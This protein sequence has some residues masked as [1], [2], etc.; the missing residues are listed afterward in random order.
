M[1]SMTLCRWGGNIILVA[2]L[3]L[4]AGCATTPGSRTAT[5]SNVGYWLAE[6][7][8]NA[9]QKEFH[10][11]KLA[12]AEFLRRVKSDMP[13]TLHDLRAYRNQLLVPVEIRA[14]FSA[15]SPGLR[16]LSQA[17]IA[18]IEDFALTHK[19]QGAIIGSQCCKEWAGELARITPQMAALEEKVDQ[20]VRDAETLL[21]QGHLVEADKAWQ[22]ARNKDRDGANVLRLEKQLLVAKNKDALE[23]LTAEIGN[24]FVKRAG[25][26]QKTFGSPE[27]NETN[28][29]ACLALLADADRAVARYRDLLK[30]ADGQKFSSDDVDKVL[31]SPEQEISTLRGKCWAEQVRLLAARKAHWSAHQYADARSREAATMAEHRRTAA[32][33]PLMDAYKQM[34]PAAVSDMVNRANGQLE[35]DACGIALT[36]CRMAEEMLQFG[37]DRQIQ[38]PAEVV[39]WEKRCVE[40]RCDAQKKIA[41]VAPRRL[42]IGDFS[43]LTKENQKLSALVLEICSGLLSGSGT[44]MARFVTVAKLDEKTKGADCVIVCD[45]PEMSVVETPPVEIERSVLKIGRDIR[46]IPN[47]Q[48]NPE[49][50]REPKTLFSQEVYLYQVIRRQCAKRVRLQANLT[51]IQGNQ[52]K[53]LLA[54]DTDSSD[55]ATKLAGVRLSG[56]EEHID[57]PFLGAPR[58][59]A[60]RS[61]LAVDPWPRAV[62]AML[63]SDADTAEAMQK[64]AAGKMADAVIA[65]STSY[66]VEVLATEA[67]RNEKIGNKSEAA[68]SWGKCLESCTQADSGKGE[69][70]WIAQK[71]RML[72]VISDLCKT[73]WKNSD[74]EVLKK[75]PDLWNEATSSALD[76]VAGQ[77]P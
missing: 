18:K 11:A 30:T 71:E 55:A 7:D 53:H 60:T 15:D 42:L 54:I 20:M 48:Y 27:S 58:I 51:A 32:L 38:I 75:M 12:T 36:L 47:P 76:A 74:P 46:E 25:D 70:S 19:A 69:F 13:A 6:I 62:P 14:L 49:S 41:A 68:N 24:K 50:K 33:A 67:V 72:A 63:S 40:T 59:S 8:G 37:R 57:V 52:K 34:L 61:S 64:Y 31:V 73:T 10:A 9:A 4:V 3:A 56:E 16:G 23:S 21:K 29:A 1:K 77:N 39:I 28:T 2:A 17:E 22:E 35:R 43:P 44:N 45:A 5:D 65:Y 26:L 66:P